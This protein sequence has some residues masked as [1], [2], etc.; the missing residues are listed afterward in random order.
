MR[1][2]ARVGVCR[3]TH[4]SFTVLPLTAEAEEGNLHHSAHTTL[5]A[6]ARAHAHALTLILTLSLTLNQ[7]RKLGTERFD[8]AAF[9]GATS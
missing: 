8:L 1:V 4:T 2:R 3:A 7:E 9:A 5:H 6:H